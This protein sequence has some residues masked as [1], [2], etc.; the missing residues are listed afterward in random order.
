MLNTPRIG[1]NTFLR[2]WL[3]FLNGRV[4]VALLFTLQHAAGLIWQLPVNPDT[5]AICVAY[6]AL[7]LLVRILTRTVPSPQ[8]GP[9]WLPTIGVDIVMFSYLH[10]FAGDVL[11]YTPLY[12]LPV[13]MAGMLG[14]LMMA[15]GT[16][17]II[18]I[19]LLAS[20]LWAADHSAGDSTRR[21]LQAALT[22]V[23]FF[24]VTYLVHQL[25]VKLHAEHEIARRNRIAAKTQEDVSALVMQHLGE[26]VLVIDRQDTVRLVNP[27]ARLLLGDAAPAAMPFELSQL[28]Q[29]EPL[30]AL[31][32]KTFENATQQSADIAIP[33]SGHS[34]MGLRARTWLTTQHGGIPAHRPQEPEDVLCVVFLQDLREMEARLRTEKLAAMGRMSAAV[35]HEF[36]NPLA[37]ILQA[38]ALLQEEL[39]DPVQLRLSQMVRQNA[40]RLTRITEEVLDI[41]RVRHQIDN[42]PSPGIAL[43]DS[44]RQMVHDWQ[45]QDP[46]RRKALLR[47]DAPQAEV[48][49]DP[50]H[51]RRV[52][53]NLMD[54]ALRYKGAHEDSMCIQS[55]TTAEG[56]AFVYV[57]SDGAPLE[58]SVEQHLFEPFFSSESRSS[59]L[60]LY[61][62]RELCG[63]HGA[64]IR[65]E[66]SILPLDRGDI[67]GNIFIVSFRQSLRLSGTASLFDT[68]MV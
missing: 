65:Y 16:T 48:N 27:S 36:R 30:L 41:A 57:W 53:V 47:L 22:C 54:N 24:I 5:L 63:R 10:I 20:S 60:G 4:M 40:D 38:N 49:F 8:P 1:N 23:G 59:G 25:S 15:L 35:A 26:G 32:R 46:A 55:G 11:S 12:G 17:S 62:S 9:Q 18:T 31:V 52:L 61:I 51:L 43:D 45:G 33:Q 39:N 28:P 67:E 50:D 44:V 19:V 68:I 58:K 13:L 7:T 37:A 21:Y 56:A 14:T 64:T 2:I 34:P 29:W 42:A 66:R 6:L 3:A